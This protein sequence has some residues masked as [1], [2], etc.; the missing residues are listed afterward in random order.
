MDIQGV[1][2]RLLAQMVDLGLIQDPADLFFLTKG[3]LMNMERMGD[4]LADNIL[5]A[6][7]AA[8]RPSLAALIYALGIRN[9]GSHLAGVLARHFGSVENLSRQ[10]PEALSE[11]REIGPVVAESITH[12]FENPKNTAVLEKLEQ[13]GVVFPAEQIESSGE[14][15]LAGKTFV[16]TGGLEGYT[17]ESARKAVEALG[18]RASGSVS[19]KTDYVVAG[20]EAGSKLEKAEKLGVSILTEEGF[21]DLL[22]ERGGK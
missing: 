9:V 2:T 18:G 17:R 14:Q 7:E 16:F 8:R 4:K 6:I 1:G 22:S 20:K 13:G 12:F 3:D 15:P 21:N 10:T 11:I 5:Q 19:G